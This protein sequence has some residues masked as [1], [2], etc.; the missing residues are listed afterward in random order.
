MITNGHV[1]TG[2]PTADKALKL[3]RQMLDTQRSSAGFLSFMLFP[4]IAIAAIA[5]VAYELVR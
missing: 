2:P 5:F 1:E 3:E 4:L